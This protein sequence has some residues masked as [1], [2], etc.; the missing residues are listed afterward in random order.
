M[1]GGTVGK[2]IRA[3]DVARAMDVSKT[4]VNKAI[5]ILMEKGFVIQPYYGGVTLTQDGYDYGLAMRKRQRYLVAFL[6]K[7]L[8]IGQDAA[9]REARLMGH[10]ISDDSFG[11]W[12]DYVNR[13]D[14]M[15]GQ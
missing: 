7:A 4:S 12:V 3:I 1:L 14:L 15:D 2:P 11:K 5:C 8:G 6:T 9:E 10:A 13:L